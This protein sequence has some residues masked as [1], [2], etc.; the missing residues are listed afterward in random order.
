MREALLDAQYELLEKKRRAVVILVNGVDGAGKGETVNLLNEWMDRATSAPRRLRRRDHQAGPPHAL[1]LA[2]APAEGKVSI[3]S[4][5]GT[6]CRSCGARRRRSTTPRSTRRWT[7]SC[8]SSACS[9]RRAWCWSSSG[10]LS[11]K[12]QEER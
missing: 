8:A 9:T 10:S 1:A 2:R 7:R 12:Q 3:S 6:P 11:K 4:G 5:A